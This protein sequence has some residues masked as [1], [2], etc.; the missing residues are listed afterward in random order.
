[1]GSMDNIKYKSLSYKSDI[2]EI[3]I[4]SVSKT[5]QIYASKTICNIPGIFQL[6]YI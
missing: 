2:C 5:F 3:N 4:N 6:L 1:M